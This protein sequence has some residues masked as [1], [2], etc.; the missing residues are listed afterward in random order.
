[1]APRK[2]VKL[3][4]YIECANRGMSKAQAGKELGVSKQTVAVMSKKY[5]IQF[6]DGRKK[7]NKSAIA[8]PEKCRDAR[9]SQEE[10]EGHE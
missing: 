8:L 7:E 10:G 4:A 9:E 2:M 6:K 5:L 3:L 1:M